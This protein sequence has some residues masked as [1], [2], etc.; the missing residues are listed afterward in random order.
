[1]ATQQQW[2]RLNTDVDVKVRRGAWY[3]ILKLGPLEV[4][5]DVR[6]K[7]V[8]VPRP[9]LEIEPRPPMKWAVVR[10]PSRAARLPASWGSVYAVC[11]N[12]RERAKL[13]GRPVTLRCVRCN[14]SFA[15]AWDWE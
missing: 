15:V 12:C 5:L 13:E 8:P 9:F 14:G 11:P 3:R 1:M 2:A 7:Q 4:V 10:R 6:G